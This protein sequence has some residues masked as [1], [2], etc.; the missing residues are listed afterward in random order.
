ML[1]VFIAA[2]VI[3]LVAIALLLSHTISV[4]KAFRKLK[5]EYK[6]ADNGQS[7]HTVHEV[8]VALIE[9]ASDMTISYA[10]MFTLG[11]E[12]FDCMGWI[13]GLI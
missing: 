11:F 8:T 6:K 4:E 9:C 2:L 5:K 7:K 3:I 10:I 13:G 12:V 1:Y